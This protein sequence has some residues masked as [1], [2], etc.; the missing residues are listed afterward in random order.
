MIRIVH[1]VIHI[2]HT[3]IHIAHTGVDPTRALVKGAVVIEEIKDSELF[4]NNYHIM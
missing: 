4:T 3:L 1:T 2:V